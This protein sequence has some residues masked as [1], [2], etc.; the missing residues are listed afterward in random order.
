MC[1]TAED[2]VQK[3][4]EQIQE[5]VHLQEDVEGAYLTHLLLSEQMTVTEIL[6]SITELLLAGVDTVRRSSDLQCVWF[7]FLT[8]DFSSFGCF[9]FLQGKFFLSVT[10]EQGLITTDF[11]LL[12]F[13]VAESS[14]QQFNLTW[15]PKKS[16]ERAQKYNIASKQ[17]KI[18]VCVLLFF[19]PPILYHGLCISWQR[20]QRSKNSYTRK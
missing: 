2:L 9:M 11:Y 1:L 14:R 7:Y 20:S 10:Y 4:I 5:K 8:V 3:K 13:N 12:Y 15:M 19:R 16:T 17:Q 6:G 18:T